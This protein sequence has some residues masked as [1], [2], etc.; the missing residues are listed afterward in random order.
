MASE[1]RPEAMR[2]TTT[3]N[4]LRKCGACKERYAHLVAALGGVKAD[5][6]APINLLGILRINGI[7]DCE[8]VLGEGATVE[9]CAPLWAEYER[10]RA[11]L[12]A[13]YLR[14]RAPLWAEYK[15]QSAPLLAEYLRQRASLWAEY[16]RQRAPL[17]DEYERQS[18]PLWAEYER[19]C[20]TLWAEY[21]RQSAP[22]LAALLE[23]ADGK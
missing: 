1:K 21:G 17:W 2:L 5:H 4:L 16:E 20:D 15:R 8:W 18:A 7:K 10:Q 13:E 11:S 19:Q 14:Q 22:L 23:E 3:L 6:D 9:D 12:R